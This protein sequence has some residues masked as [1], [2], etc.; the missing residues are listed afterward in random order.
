M[1]YVTRD[2]YGAII[3][4]TSTKTPDTTEVKS[5]ID[6]EVVDFL[7]ETDK[8]DSLRVSMSLLDVGL[9]RII[10]DL[11]ELLIEKKIIYFTELPL[12]AQKKIREHQNIRE[13]LSSE[14][15]MVEDVL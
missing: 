8:K 1:L 7:R 12:E 11:I 2:K 10:E 15:L 6:A 9:I 4:L 3:A 14:S 13:K 5:F